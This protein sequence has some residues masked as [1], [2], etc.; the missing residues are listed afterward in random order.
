MMVFREGQKLTAADL[1]QMQQMLLRSIRPGPGIMIQPTGGG[2][3][4]SR[5][6][7]RLFIDEGGGG[8]GEGYFVPIVAKLPLIPIIGMA[9]VFWATTQYI[10]GGTGDNQVWRAYQGQKLWFPTQFRTDRI[11]LP[12]L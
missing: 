2:I 12:G 10:A 8:G 11:G 9:E 1:N 5:Q 7:D 6:K 3:C 4:I